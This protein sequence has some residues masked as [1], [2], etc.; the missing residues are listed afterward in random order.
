VV[1][2]L[3]AELKGLQEQHDQKLAALRRDL[4]KSM[5]D[6]LDQDRDAAWRE[7]A[8]RL[9]PPYGDSARQLRDDAL[10]VM[11][12]FRLPDRAPDDQV[13]FPE[14][15][16]PD[17]GD[18]GQE[19]QALERQR[20]EVRAR[21]ADALVARRNAVMDSI[22]SATRL[23]AEKIGRDRGLRLVYP[24]GVPPAGP[25]LTDEIGRSVRA[26]WAGASQ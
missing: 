21:L 22:L 9:V 10:R 20:R 7:A 11:G 15:V 23:A 26:L 5:A 12:A 17:P 18:P 8:Q 2:E 6:K 16:L 3:E 24:P 19:A 1:A 4:E 13:R 14:P 25:D